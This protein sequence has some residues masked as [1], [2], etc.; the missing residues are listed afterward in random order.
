[1]SFTILIGLQECF[2]ND[3]FIQ[4]L[5]TLKIKKTAEVYFDSQIDFFRLIGLTLTH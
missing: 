2:M 4:N 3:K 5:N 1:M